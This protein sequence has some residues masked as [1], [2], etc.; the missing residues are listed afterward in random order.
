MAALTCR[1]LTSLDDVLIDKKTPHNHTH[2]IQI[3]LV[4]KSNN[5]PPPLTSSLPRTLLK[6]TPRPLT[7]RRLAEQRRQALF[8]R[9]QLPPP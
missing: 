8:L 3:D 5:L 1:A 6:E 9:M 4:I 2:T 7:E